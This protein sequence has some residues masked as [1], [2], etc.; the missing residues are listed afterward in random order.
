MT[1]GSDRPIDASSA[2]W[3]AVAGGLPAGAVAEAQVGDLD[4]VVWRTAGGR[5]CVFEAR[6]PHQWS[7]LAFEGAVDGD[8]L[9]CLAHFW[10]FDADGRGTK[11]NVKGRR[12]DKADIAT[13]ECRDDGEVIWLRDP[14]SGE[15]TRP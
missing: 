4:L 2:G 3:I 13:F 5:P 12:D 1:G 10:R 7:H 6:C 9:V 14:G 11:V 8:E 15:D